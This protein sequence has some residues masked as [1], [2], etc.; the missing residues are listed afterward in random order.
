VPVEGVV[1]VKK[2]SKRVGGEVGDA[3]LYSG[4]PKIEH[5]RK[6]VKRG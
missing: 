2:N 3:S 1:E 5:F 4:F 6:L